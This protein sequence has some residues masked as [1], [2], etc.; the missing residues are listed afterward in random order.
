MSI[1]HAQPGEV[2]NVKPLGPAL[3]TT[4]TRTLLKDD[5]VELIRLVIPS[6]KELPTHQAKGAIVVHCL[7]GRIHFTARGKSQT[8]EAGQLIF[9]PAQEPHS[10]KGITDA[11]LLL[12]ILLQ[13]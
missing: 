12:T 5:A 11:S 9:L 2:V 10:V 3:P 13:K 4:P 8:L 1:P 7:E 6:G